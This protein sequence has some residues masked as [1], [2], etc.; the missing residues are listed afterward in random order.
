MRKIYLS[1]FLL[2]GLLGGCKPGGNEGKIL[3]V[4][5]EPQRFF[6]EKIAGNTYK[7]NTIVPPGTSPETYEPT[8]AIMIDLGKSKLY[9]KVGSLGFENAWSQNLAQNN[10]DVKIVDCSRGIELIQG[11]HDHASHDESEHNHVSGTDPHVWSS[12]KTAKLFAEN[13]YRAL[14]FSDP[15][16]VQTYK[17]NFDNLEKEIAQTDSI[18]TA[19]LSNIPSRSFIIYHPALSYFARDYG[20]EQHSIEFEGKKPSPA[21]MKELID[22]ARKENIRVVFVQKGF[23]AKNADVVAAELGAK[24]YEINPLAYE[25]KD[26]MIRIA[27]ILAGKTDE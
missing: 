10:P 22:L 1:F 8:P 15:E 5:I 25:W 2:L 18:V 13:M 23:D 20:L 24:L 4:T 14:V 21:Q 27:R 17:T 11:S 16:N 26:E 6:L 7:I 3:S 19:L 9:F 12:P